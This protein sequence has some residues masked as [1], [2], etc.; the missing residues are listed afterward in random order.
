[1]MTVADDVNRAETGESIKLRLLQERLDTVE[2]QRLVQ[3]MIALLLDQYLS[4]GQ[5]VEGKFLRKNK[6]IPPMRNGRLQILLQEEEPLEVVTSGMFSFRN[7]RSGEEMPLLDKCLCFVVSFINENEED[8]TQEE[9]T[10]EEEGEE[11]EEDEAMDVGEEEEVREEDVPTLHPDELDAQYIIEWWHESISSDLTLS[12]EQCDTFQDMFH[13][14]PVKEQS[15]VLR[16]LADQE[17]R[18]LSKPN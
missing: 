17:S 1:M 3:Q 10:Q 16:F 7:K 15:K 14:L 12:D 4:N 6:K 5:M 11:E 2:Y 8:H 13:R 9:H 18:K